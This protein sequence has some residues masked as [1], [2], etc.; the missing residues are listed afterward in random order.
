MAGADGVEATCKGWITLWGLTRVSKPTSA[1]GDSHEVC[2]EMMGL[3]V[4]GL[5][6]EDLPL[7]SS[8]WGFQG[9]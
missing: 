1:G 7:A 2:I 3:G 4:T 6:C 5:T 8:V 9:R